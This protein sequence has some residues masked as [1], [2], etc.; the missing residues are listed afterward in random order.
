MLIV[1][2]MGMSRSILYHRKSLQLYSLWRIL[3]VK[4]LLST[5]YW[6]FLYLAGLFISLLSLSFIFSSFSNTEKAKDP[7]LFFLTFQLNLTFIAFQLFLQ[8]VFALVLFV[9]LD[10]HL[11]FKKNNWKEFE[12]EIVFG[13]ALLE[14]N[15]KCC[16]GKTL[17]ITLELY[18][19]ILRFYYQNLPEMVKIYKQTD[20][21]KQNLKKK[22]SDNF[23]AK[24]ELS[25][26][27][28]VAPKLS[29]WG[30]VTSVRTSCI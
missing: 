28:Q 13:H 7:P 2:D 15:L 17:K 16:E 22:N 1:V 29:A 9:V 10:K 8:H 30:H 5:E 23:M 27:T 20:I 25:L 3:Y 26:R 14:K 21:W 4:I 6:A 19:E 11:F 24:R 18:F 12:I